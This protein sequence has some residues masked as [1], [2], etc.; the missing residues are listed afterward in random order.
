MGKGRANPRRRARGRRIRAFA[1]TTAT[2]FAAGG[3]LACFDASA[4]SH[5]A[6]A[7]LAA[8]TTP[9]VVAGR[10]FAVEVAADPQSRQRGLS[11]RTAIADNGGMLFVLPEPAP[12]AMVMRDC[13][14]AIDV[15]FIDS[16]GRVIAIHEMPPESPRRG[17]ETSFGYERRLPAYASGAP[18]SFALETRGGRLAELE[19][20]V[21]ARVH[22]AAQELIER[23]RHSEAAR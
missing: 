23:A 18:V 21:G 17:G 8:H 12:M 5:S 11:G 1:W 15:A 4:P 16:M 3:G 6:A 2:I 20:A 13:P 7:P 19:L 10:T 14:N 22:F 9:V